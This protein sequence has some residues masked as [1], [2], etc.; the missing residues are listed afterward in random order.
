MPSIIINSDG[1]RTA[2]FI[3]KYIGRAEPVEARAG[4]VIIMNRDA[5]CLV[6]ARYVCEF[7]H[8]NGAS[9]RPVNV[10]GGKTRVGASSMPLRAGRGGAGRGGR[11]VRSGIRHDPWCHFFPFFVF[12][13]IRS[14]SLETR[15]P[16]E[17]QA[18]KNV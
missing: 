3:Y 14:S 17:T 1:T 7:T 2:I 16:S 4:V 8:M 13:P 6:K 18:E 10:R 5:S 9:E 11:C 12:A 15:D